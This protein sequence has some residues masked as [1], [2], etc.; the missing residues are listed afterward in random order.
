[1]SGDI[2]ARLRELGLE[3]PPAPAPVANYVPYLQVGNLI[4]I[5]GQ[6]SKAGDGTLIAGRVGDTISVE[7]GVEA[8]KVCALNLLAQAQA[9][10]GDLNRIAQV[11]RLTGF[12]NAG[13]DF[14]Y[15]PKVINGASDLM[16][17][18]L[19][20]NGRHTRAAVGVS[21]LPAGAA[22]EVDGIFS[23]S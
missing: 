3:L 4:Y 13:P 1:M 12:V 8:A 17:A 6:I 9:A 22:V 21:G 16:V 20:D 11:V 10:A 5:S 2:A 7:Q 23:V 15:H 19:G 14:T 18:V